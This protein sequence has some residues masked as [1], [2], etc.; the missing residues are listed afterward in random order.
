MHAFRE[1]KRCIGA[2]LAEECRPTWIA[3]ECHLRFWR[4]YYSAEREQRRNSITLDTW[5]AKLP[6]ARRARQKREPE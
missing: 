4:A 2:E 3:Q 6:R 5:P 1:A